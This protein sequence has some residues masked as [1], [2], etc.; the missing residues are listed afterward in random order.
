MLI[1]YWWRAKP[2]SS[3]G[4]RLRGC[5]SFGPAPAR[6]GASHPWGSLVFCFL[7]TLAFGAR[8]CQ[9]PGM[10]QSTVLGTCNLVGEIDV[11]TDNNRIM[12]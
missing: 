5:Y 8:H 3:P 2:F 6:E 1:K 7:S 4:F 10:M 11:E 12:C 9:A